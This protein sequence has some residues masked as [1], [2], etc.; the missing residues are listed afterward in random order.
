MS[1]GFKK[2]GLASVWIPDD[3]TVVPTLLQSE[4]S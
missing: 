4:P 2:I 1:L 3:T